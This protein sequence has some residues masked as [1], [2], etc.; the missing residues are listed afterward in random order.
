MPE[1]CSFTFAMSEENLQTY[2]SEIFYMDSDQ[3][4]KAAVSHIL[5]LTAVAAL[6]ACLYPLIRSFGTGEEK[7]FFAP[8]EAMAAGTAV[9]AIGVWV[10]A[11]G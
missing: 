9:V 4:P 7:V 10:N 11:E 6:A 8:L 3:L 1:D 5:I 2:L